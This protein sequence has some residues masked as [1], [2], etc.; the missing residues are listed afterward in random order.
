V[1][2]FGS[3]DVTKAYQ[4]VTAPMWLPAVLQ[5]LNVL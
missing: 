1:E 3:L 2:G 5:T 4:E